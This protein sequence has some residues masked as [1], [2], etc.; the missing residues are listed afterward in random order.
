MTT[1]LLKQWLIY[2]LKDRVIVSKPYK[3]R[4]RARLRVNKLDSAYGAYRYTVITCTT[5]FSCP[6]E[7]APQN[8]YA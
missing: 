6:K 1:N 7:L 8:N 5:D 2:D 4:L 3:S